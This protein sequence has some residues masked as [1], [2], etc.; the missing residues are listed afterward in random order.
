MRPRSVG[1]CQSGICFESRTRRRRESRR[2]EKPCFRAFITVDGSPRCGSLISKCT[3]SG[4]TTYPATTKRYLRRTCSSPPEEKVPNHEAHGHHS[5]RLKS[6]KLP[7][8]S[9]KFH[10]EMPVSFLFRVYRLIFLRSGA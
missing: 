3:C 2:R 1:A 4:I 6:P 8:A 10:S 5:R 7:V 9:V